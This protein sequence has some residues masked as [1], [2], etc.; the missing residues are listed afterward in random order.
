MFMAALFIIVKI[1]K[2]HIY[3]HN[4]HI[5]THTHTH[6]GILLSHKNE[7][8]FAI[9]NNKQ[10]PGWYFLIILFIY[11]YLAVLGLCC[12]MGFSLAVESGDYFLVLCRLLIGV[13]SLFAEHGL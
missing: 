13:A 4:M 3:I 6:S 8:I 5:H 9:Y 10:E 12:Y 2:Q 7:W 1:W 11:L